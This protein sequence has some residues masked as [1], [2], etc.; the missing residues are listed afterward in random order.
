MPLKH[1]A[2]LPKNQESGQH[3]FLHFLW[4]RFTNEELQVLKECN[5]ESFYFR[6]LPFGTVLGTAAYYAVKGG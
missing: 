1:S 4:Q 6:S 2:A 5:R 3:Y